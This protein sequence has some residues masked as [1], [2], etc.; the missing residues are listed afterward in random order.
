MTR[1][2]KQ[3][4]LDRIDE[5]VTDHRVECSRQVGQ[6]RERNWTAQAGA[7]GNDRNHSLKRDE[8]PYPR[9]VEEAQF[10]PLRSHPGDCRCR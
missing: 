6:A 7:D 10:L 1:G 3:P 9:L 4:H 5:R 8:G 2:V